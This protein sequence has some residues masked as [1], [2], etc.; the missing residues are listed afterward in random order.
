MP[1]E[2]RQIL[3]SLAGAGLAGL[4][5]PV[6]RAQEQV[7]RATRGM[8]APHIK[9]ISVIE[10]EPAGSRLTVV[11][12]ATDQDGLYGYGCA[13][14]TQRADLVKP[15]VERYLKPLLMGR[16]TDRIEDIWQT[17][18]DSSYWKNG[19]ILNNAIS[20]IDQ[21]LWD[22]KGRQAGMPVY[23]LA[24]GK[25]REAVDTYGHADGPEYSDV[26]AAARKYM[27]EGF[28]NVRVQVG[29]PGMAGYGSARNNANTLKPLHDKPLFEPA[30]AMRRGLKLLE[31]CRQELGEEVGLLHD[32]HERYTPNQAV[33]F[34]KQAEKFNLFFAEDPLSP[35]DI[36]YFKQI[37]QNCATPLAMGELFN[38]PHEWQPLIA[39]RLIDYIRCHVSQ[40]GGF[41]PARKIA[42]MAEQFG[43]KTAWHGPGD[44]SPIGH[45]A[46]I[47]LDIVSTNFGIQEYSPFNQRSQE[48]FKGCPEMRDGYL[49]VNEKPGWGIE[50]DEKEAAK[51]PFTPGRG[52]LNGGWGEIRKLDGTII[53]Q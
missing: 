28:R 41:T 8:P 27:A 4:A 10:C 35:E 49:Y 21:A 43:V 51:S 42:I 44:V 47:T 39:G 2:R 7:A 37:R 13:T 20:G 1:I 24:G 52:N 22:I 14:F 36:D 34:C 5:H 33:E 26:V 48:I 19:P 46:Q 9:D 12:I 15:A 16:T 3:K 53:K 18:Y 32:M 38:S 6:L 31:I 45:M 40:V 50:I 23:Q 11:K 30:Y 25:C 17:C 29:L